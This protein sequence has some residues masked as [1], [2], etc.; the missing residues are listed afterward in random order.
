ML[1]EEDVQKIFKEYLFDNWTFDL[2]NPLPLSKEDKKVLENISANIKKKFPNK[3][4]E[5]GL[6][7]YA[8]LNIS[9]HEG[10]PLN[11]TIYLRKVEITYDFCQRLATS[12]SKFACSFRKLEAKHGVYIDGSPTP[13]KEVVADSKDK[14]DQA[15]N[16][17]KR[18]NSEVVIESNDSKDKNDQ[19]T[20]HKKRMNS[21][22]VVESND[23]KD[24]ND[25]ATN[26]K[27]SL[28]LEE[29]KKRKNAEKEE[30]GKAKIE[31]E[32]SKLE[33]EINENIDDLLETTDEEKI[34]HTTR[35]SKS[36]APKVRFEEKTNED[37]YERQRRRSW[38]REEEDKKRKSMNR[39]EDDRRKRP[40]E[41]E[42]AQE[43]R[44]EEDKKRK[45]MNREEDDR[46]KRPRETE[47]AQEDK[48]EDDK[49]RND[50][51]WNEGEYRS[52]RQKEMEKARED[53]EQV[54][55]RHLGCDLRLISNFMFKY[56][57]ITN[58]Q[59]INKYRRIKAAIF[60]IREDLHESYY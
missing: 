20:N 7:I 60:R 9:L 55:R 27:K 45:S 59:D 30:Q 36:V 3:H 43:N 54:L 48:E 14:N 49:R 4:Y 35:R 22:V 6:I 37:R 50:M 21:E 17:K 18:M 33:D 11:K 12:D 5:P 42:K 25:Q 53:M 56:Q 51:E 46:R 24:K 8:L 15:T 1:R 19:A 23:S 16:H 57:H 58:S 32:I 10:D 52:R 31:E 13:T 40:R 26:S 2:Q 41:T 34:I 38:D 29:W 39:E 47:K 28:T 44:E